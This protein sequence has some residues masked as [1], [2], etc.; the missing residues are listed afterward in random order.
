MTIIYMDADMRLAEPVNPQQRLD[1]QTWCPGASV[2]EVI[3]IPSN[4][5][6]YRKLGG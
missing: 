5:V 6:L 1:W 3:D 4:P 2:G